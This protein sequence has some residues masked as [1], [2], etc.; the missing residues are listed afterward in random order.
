MINPYK[1]IK[2]LSDLVKSPEFYIYESES[3]SLQ[4]NIINKKKNPDMVTHQDI[5]NC[6]H[7]FLQI[8][9]R[10]LTPK[11]SNKIHN[12]ILELEKYHNQQGT[13]LDEVYNYT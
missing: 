6:M 7:D 13:I 3:L 5:I 1:K 12:E 11:T 2:T 10:H 4:S 9:D 8:I